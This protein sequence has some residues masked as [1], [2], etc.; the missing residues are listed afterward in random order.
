MTTIIEPETKYVPDPVPDGAFSGCLFIGDSRTEGLEMTGSLPG[1]DV[2]AT[3]GL[4]IYGAIS[5]VVDT[6]PGV[7][8][9]TLTDLLSIKQ[10]D[11]I[12]ILLGINEIGGSFSALAEKHQYLI[13]TIHSKQ[14][15]AK[16][17]YQANLHVTTWRSNQELA[18]NG[19]F[20]N[21]NVN[22]LNEE[23]K[24][25]T[26]GTTVLWIDPNT[27]LDDSSGGLSEEYEGGDGIHLNWNSY[28]TWGSW[29]AEQNAKY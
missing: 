16:I 2:F 17:I 25:L 23:L 1:A 24:K 28:A 18:S 9:V 7:G 12:Y 11:K 19:C 13:D 6:I 21:N 22:G 8:E 4:S 5:S 14:T 26:N 29:I 10:Y 15:N 20:N 3:T 27:I